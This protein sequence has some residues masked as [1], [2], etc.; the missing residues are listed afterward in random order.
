[1]KI[2][3]NIKKVRNPLHANPL[4]RKGGV[5]EKSK[6]TKR[7]IEKQKLKDEWGSLIIFLSS[8]IKERHLNLN[9]TGDYYELL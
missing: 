7:R 4:M 5:H 9:R 8:V 6:K 2:K 1:M 3:I